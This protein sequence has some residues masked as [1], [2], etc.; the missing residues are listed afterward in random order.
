MAQE[1]LALVA[2]VAEE[3]CGVE[4]YVD[5]SGRAMFGR[6]C[7]GFALDR[8]VTPLAFFGRLLEAT[9]DLVAEDREAVLA[10]LPKMMRDAQMDTLGLGTIIYFP[11]FYAPGVED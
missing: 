8:N 6:T 2:E 7:V 9:D 3:M 1:M 10:E 11:H 4:L 5:Y